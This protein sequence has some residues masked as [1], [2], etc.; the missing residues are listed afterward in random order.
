[1]TKIF[2]TYRY[3][4][5]RNGNQYTPS[6][7]WGNSYPEWNKLATIV[8]EKVTSTN[9]KRLGWIECDPTLVIEVTAELQN[10]W[11]YGWLIYITNYEA[12]EYMKRLTD[13]VETTPW[14]FELTPETDLMWTFVPATYLVID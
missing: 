9:W 10:Y 8:D 6:H 3:R 7:E 14:T 1:M 5:D 2:Y 4:T 11:K 13:Y 12:L